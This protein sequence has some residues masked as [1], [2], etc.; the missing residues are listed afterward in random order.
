MGQRLIDADAVIQAQREGMESIYGAQIDVIREHLG[1]DDEL[2]VPI[3]AMEAYSRAKQFFA[4]LK[5]ILEA[6]PP[7]DAVPVVR[8]RDCEHSYESVSGLFCAMGPCV[9]CIV[10]EDFFCGHGERR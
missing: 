7:V 2:S 9:D 8:C 4:G 6:A 3:H 5:G 10:P 1:I